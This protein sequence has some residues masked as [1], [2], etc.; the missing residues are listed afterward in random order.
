MGGIRGDQIR[1]GTLS[2]D[3]LSSQAIQDIGQA[4]GATAHAEVSPP[5]PPTGVVVG[6][7][8]Q[9]KVLKLEAAGMAVRTTTAGVTYNPAGL[10]HEVDTEDELAIGAADN[11]DPRIDAVVVDA[12]G[13]YAVRAGTPAADPEAPAL[14]EGDVLLAYVSIAAQQAQIDTMDIYDQRRRA[15]PASRSEEEEGDDATDAWELAFRARG[16]VVVKR[17][18]VGLR[19]VDADPATVDEYT[20]TDPWDSNGT[21]IS[22]GGAPADADGEDPADLIEFEYHG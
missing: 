16:K 14:E 15:A 20:Q 19:R 7:G 4:L 13:A 12:D 6:E 18:G 2:A 5:I 21:L 3:R 17:N 10:R 9:L 8:D 22:L 11:D 1:A